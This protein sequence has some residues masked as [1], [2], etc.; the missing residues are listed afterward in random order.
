[1]A[2]AFRSLPL[3]LLGI[4]AFCQSPPTFAASRAIRENRLVSPKVTKMRARARQART[5]SNLAEFRNRVLKNT[6]LQ[7]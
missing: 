4:R 3:R 7:K 5:F 2:L 1:M 6:Y